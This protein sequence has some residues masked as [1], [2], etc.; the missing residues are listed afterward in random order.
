MGKNKDKTVKARVVGQGVSTA[1]AIMLTELLNIVILGMWYYIAFPAIN[2]HSRGFWTML[3]VVFSVDFV[4]VALTKSA[5]Q[6]LSGMGFRQT[7]KSFGSNALILIIIDFILIMIVV[8]GSVLGARIFRSRSYAGLLNVETR[9]FNEDVKESQSV[10]NIALM[11]TASAR[12]F[13]NR[14]IGSLSD[15]VSQYEVESSYNQISLSGIPMKVSPLKYASFFKWINNRNSGVPGYVKVNPVNS[16]AKYEKLKSGLKYVPSAFLNDN[17]M[18]HVQFKYPTKIISGHYFEIDEEGNPYFICPCMT[19]KVG[20]FGG[21]DVEGVIICDPITG[22]AEYYKVGD[23]P[24][25]VDH[26]YDGD[27]CALKYDWHGIYSGGYWN[28][29]FSQTGCTRTTD[30]YGY[31]IIDDDVWMYTGVTSLNADNSNVGFVMINERTS[32]ARYYVVSGAEEDSAMRSA[33]GAVQEK[34][35]EASFPS[36][37]NVAGQPTYIMVLKDSGGLVKMYAMVNVEQY[38]IVAT[39]TSQSE[40]FKEYKKMLKSEGVKN[41]SEDTEAVK[42]NATIAD[43]QY[44]VNDGETTVYIKDTNHR[45][46]QQNFSENEELI[47]L[48]VG[49]YVTF[50]LDEMSE[51]TDTIISIKGFK[52]I[53]HS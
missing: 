19:A 45:V 23:I 10:T 53:N 1:K 52:I 14:E 39:A 41:V 7:V 47:T 4:I 9:D 38:N 22:G 29:V 11:D 32:E 26:V 20:L 3:I 44:I 25:W 30:D 21:M 12:I 43:I 18:R 31:I 13:G 5:G 16:D 24:K 50:E 37:I 48:S 2:V 35:Y 34:N 6:A 46:Y 36:L 51:L 28:T 15:V 33:E 42:V 17:L 8:I 49:D 40:V 27:L